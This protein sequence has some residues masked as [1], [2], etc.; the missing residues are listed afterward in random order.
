MM[1]SMQTNM[2]KVYQSIVMVTALAYYDEYIMLLIYIIL[3]VTN[4]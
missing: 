2:E 4:Q 1:H 3:E